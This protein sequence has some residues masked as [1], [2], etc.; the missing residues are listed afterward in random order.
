MSK[1]SIKRF[2]TVLKGA[3]QHRP[4]YYIGYDKKSKT[5][6]FIASRRNQDLFNLAM[7]E[8]SKPDL[9]YPSH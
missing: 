8:C 1:K 3:M 4:V 7:K 6:V 9:T 5:H 2:R